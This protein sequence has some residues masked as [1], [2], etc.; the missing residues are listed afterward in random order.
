MEVEVIKMQ[1]DLNSRELVEKVKSQDTFKN[2]SR[3]ISE[4]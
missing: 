3:V 2:A 1:I 4:S